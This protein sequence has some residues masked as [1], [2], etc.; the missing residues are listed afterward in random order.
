MRSTPKNFY[1]YIKHFWVLRRRMS[2]AAEV[3]K[4]K[5][6]KSKSAES[7]RRVYSNMTLKTIRLVPA[8][9][10]VDGGVVGKT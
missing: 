5:L 7:S 2:P 10:A 8:I 3:L 9:Y 1:D 4:I 6:Q